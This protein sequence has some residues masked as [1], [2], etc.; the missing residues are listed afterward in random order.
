MICVVTPTAHKAGGGAR[1]LRR[2]RCVACHAE[3]NPWRLGLTNS[4]DCQGFDGNAML[5]RATV[6]LTATALA[7]AGADIIK[8]SDRV[9]QRVARL[10]PKPRGRIAALARHPSRHLSLSEQAEGVAQPVMLWFLLLT[11][12]QRIYY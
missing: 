3:R 11:S 8:D 9:C 4:Q 12:P 6:G 2:G 5:E 10:R 7:L 1:R